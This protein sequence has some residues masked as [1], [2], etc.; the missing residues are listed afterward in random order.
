M[1]VLQFSCEWWLPCLIGHLDDAGV[2]FICEPCTLKSALR[3][4]LFGGGK[5]GQ[6]PPLI[7]MNQAAK[8]AHSQM[9]FRD[10]LTGAIA[11]LYIR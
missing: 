6:T 9:R 10:G 7:A 8:N 4:Q 11:G 3:F 2:K 5:A 1:I